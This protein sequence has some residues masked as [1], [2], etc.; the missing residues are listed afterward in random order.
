[1]RSGLMFE[2]KTRRTKIHPQ[3]SF[4]T[5]QKDPEARRIAENTIERG[6][7]ECWETI[8]KF[9]AEIKI[10]SNPKREEPELIP[11]PSVDTAIAA[12][13]KSATLAELGEAIASLG[14]RG[15]W[16]DWELKHWSKN[17]ECRIYVT[18]RSY[19]NAKQRGYL[20]ILPSGKIE[21]FWKGN[22]DFPPLPPLPITIDNPPVEKLDAHQRAFRNLSGEYGVNGWNQLDLE[23]ELERE[24]YQ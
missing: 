7:I 2:A 4:Y 6:Q 16:K 8:D 15:Q 21:Q 22:I 17:G 13:S 14:G 24:E 11:T 20:Q 19:A 18:D 9:L 23:D 12:I 5:G 3:L 1:M 10:A